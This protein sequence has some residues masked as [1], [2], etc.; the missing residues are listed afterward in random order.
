ME[1]NVMLVNSRVK[2]CVKCGNNRVELNSAGFSCKECGMIPQRSKC[3]SRLQELNS[4]S[5]L[6]SAQYSPTPV[7]DANGLPNKGLH[8]IPSIL[9][10]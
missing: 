1:A 3:D 7:T 9:F 6:Q 8:S 2:I 5:K 10:F 4:K